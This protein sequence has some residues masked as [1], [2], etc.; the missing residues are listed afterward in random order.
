MWE[1]SPGMSDFPRE[2]LSER[3]KLHTPWRRPQ[4]DAQLRR[5]NMP[6]RGSGHLTSIWMSCKEPHQ[7]QITYVL[8]QHGWNERNGQNAVGGRYLEASGVASPAHPRPQRRTGLHH[9]HKYCVRE[10][11]DF[12]VRELKNALMKEATMGQVK[13]TNMAMQGAATFV[14]FLK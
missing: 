5:L 11:C 2:T 7:G 13:A 14:K 9:G 1:S 4:M 3:A 12:A 10:S 6:G 8:L